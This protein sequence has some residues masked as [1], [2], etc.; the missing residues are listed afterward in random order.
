M[1]EPV[2]VAV[3]RGHE[4]YLLCNCERH[5]NYMKHGNGGVRSSKKYML[6]EMIFRP[7]FLKHEATYTNTIHIHHD[8]RQDEGARD[9]RGRP[10]PPP[11]CLSYPPVPWP[12]SLTF[13]AADYVN[14][15]RLSLSC[16]QH[17]NSGSETSP[18]CKGSRASCFISLRY[19]RE[20]I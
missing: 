13:Q 11:P 7:L 9:G 3:P 6:G 1:F 14:Y 20:K 8:R 16:V 12:R 10:G 5:T 2:I 17:Y 15:S 18:V 4:K 19:T